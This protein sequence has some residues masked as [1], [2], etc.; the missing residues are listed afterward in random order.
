MGEEDVNLW[1]KNGGV[2]IGYEAEDTKGA[3]PLLQNPQRYT[4]DRHIVLVGP[5][6]SGK[7]KRFIFPAVAELTGWSLFINDIKRELYDMTAAHRAA[8][9][10]LIIRLDPFGQK[11]DGLNPIAAL[12][13]DDDFPDDAMELAEAVVR[14]EGREPHWAQ[15]AQEL[16]AGLIMYVRLVIKDGSFADVRTLLGLNFKGWQRLI[17]AGHNT[18]PRQLELW[19]KSDEEDRDPSYEP[20]FQHE[21]K[22]YPGVIAASVLYDWPELETKLGRYG[23][24]SPDNREMLSVI[25]TALTQTRWLDSRHIKA[26]LAKNPVDFSIAKERPVTVYAILPPR[27]LT[28][29]SAWMRLMITTFVQKLM[30][31]T[32]R[33]KVPVMLVLDEYAAIAG[34]S[35]SG[36]NDNGDGFPIIARNMPMFRGYGIK[37]L[38]AWQDLAQAKRIYG[39]GFETFIGN[40]GVL[41]AF[42]PQ[43]VV[44]AEY[45]STRT[46]Q[47]AR[48]VV[49]KGRSRASNPGMPQGASVTDN[50][51][52]GVIPLPLMLPQ[53]VRN[54]DDGFTIL[55]SHV[56]DGT[57]RHFLPFPTELPHLRALVDLAPEA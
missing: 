1:E 31:D 27:R 2:Y 22:L 10:S 44:T 23:D 46:G 9:G 25:S 20:P 12:P 52:L 49:S 32:K 17:R 43:D 36:V 50:V 18:D 21:G 15:A 28:T 8:A 41:Q 48:P 47:T 19:E 45:L 37:L 34:G 51:N 11:S 29:H 39:D 14:V 35:S 57:L 33:A 16:V 40:A 3:A 26:D 55:F 38:T 4:G 13:L 53:D 7:T 30:K 24:I 6:G 54:M 5:N 56:A 42:A